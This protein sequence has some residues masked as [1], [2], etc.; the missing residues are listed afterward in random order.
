MLLLL[1][2]VGVVAGVAGVVAGVAGVAGVVVVVVIGML[3]VMSLVV[4]AGA[5]ILELCL[6][7][8]VF[9]LDSSIAPPDILVVKVIKHASSAEI[10]ESTT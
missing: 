10:I 7:L 1:G 9:S 3:T 6:Y 8:S 4:E 2:V 5:R